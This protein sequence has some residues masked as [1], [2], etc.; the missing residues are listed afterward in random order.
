[1]CWGT[2]VAAA[3][4][5][6][7]A[8]YTAGVAVIWGFRYSIA[9]RQSELFLRQS[10]VALRSGAIDGTALVAQRYRRSQRARNIAVCLAD[11]LSLVP[12]VSAAEAI[13]VAKRI[14]RLS[15]TNIHA[16]M[17]R[18]VNGL[19]TV[20]TVAPLLGTGSTAVHIIFSSFKGMGMEKSAALAANASAIGDSLLFSALGIGVGVCALW[21]HRYFSGRMEDVD[22]EMKDASRTLIHVLLLR[23]ARGK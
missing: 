19:A 12:T 10:A 7:M 3:L 4:I 21:C 2:Q 11:L 5:F 14:L 23:S 6:L 18:G 15:T 8:A 17:K 13:E 9:R 1:M 22:A 16:E 20:A